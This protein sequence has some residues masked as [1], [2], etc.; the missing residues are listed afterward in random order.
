MKHI[1]REDVDMH[2]G[3]NS[4]YQFL[5][6]VA[7]AIGLFG[8]AEQVGAAD[9]PQFMGP[10]RD[11]T[12]VEK[13][14]LKAWPETG[15]KVIWTASVGRGF[16]GAAIYKGEVFILDRPNRQQDVLRCFDLATGK[17]KWS[18]AYDAPG[19]IDRDGSRSTPAVTESRVYT[20]GPFGHFHCIDRKT[21]KPLWQKNI[22]SDYNGKRPNWAVAQSP[23][24]YGDK[25]IVAPQSATVGVVAFDQESGEERWRSEAIGPMAYASPRIV[26]IEGIDQVVCVS[27]N[28]IAAVSASDGKVLWQ[29]QHKCM[30]PVPNVSV[31]APGRLFVT[32]GYNSGSAVIEVSRNGEAWAVKEIA[33]VPQI[34]GHCHQGLVY[35]DRVYVLCN[36]NERNDG[37]VCFDADGKLVWQTK[38]DPYLCKG[39]SILTGDGTMYIMDGRSGELHIVDP[40]PDGF[41][42]LSKVKLL[43]GRDI[44]GPLALSDGRLVIRDHSQLKCV[45][46][47]AE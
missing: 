35:K 36:T 1:G 24:L 28:G 29:Y 30:I 20:I 38:R 19:S 4:S 32:A 41:K 34:G 40:S 10:N 9:W 26:T 18:F 22:L 46:I 47:R 44:W 33:R 39:G 43:D 5:T 2:K 14:L 11:G 15:P 17:E 37:L 7:L 12:S 31:L 45:D 23:L 16:G 25:V 8:L 13:G 6:G 21:G 3:K 42:S 27:P